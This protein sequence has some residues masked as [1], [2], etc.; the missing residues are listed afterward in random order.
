MREHTLMHVFQTL[1]AI[2]ET[3]P[4]SPDVQQQRRTASHVRKVL[5][6][7]DARRDAAAHLIVVQTN[8][9]AR[10]IGTGSSVRG[11]M[12]AP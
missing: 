2:T 7:A 10:A 4:L 5:Q 12:H 1:Q 9:P 8:V 6:G 11:R 3:L